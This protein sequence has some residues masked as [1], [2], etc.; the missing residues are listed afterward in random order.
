MSVYTYAAS[1]NRG[2]GFITFAQEEDAEDAIDNMH[3]NEFRGVRRFLTQNVIT[4]NA[5]KAQKL[6]TADPWRPIW[7]TEVCWEGAHSGMD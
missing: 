2:F 5:A 6:Q 3:L 4:V 7:E 1:G